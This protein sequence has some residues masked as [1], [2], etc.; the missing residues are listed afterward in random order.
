MKHLW[1]SNQRAAALALTLI[2]V[3]ILTA[4]TGSLIELGRADLGNAGHYISNIRAHSLAQS[5]LEHALQRLT[6][7][8][9]FHDSVH[10]DCS[11]GS[12]EFHFDPSL[13]NYSVNNLLGGAPSSQLN[14]QSNVVAP[15]RVDLVVLGRSGSVSTRLHAVCTS[16]LSLT[17]SAGSD[18]SI[19]IQNTSEVGGIRSLADPVPVGG[20]LFTHFVS[21]STAVPSISV[22]VS[23]FTISSSSTVAAP[24][25]NGGQDIAGNVPVAQKRSQCSDK[26]PDID[27]HDLVSLQSALSAPSGLTPLGPGYQVF[28]PS[29]SG[30]K[31]VDKDLVVRGDLQLNRGSLYIKGDLTV[32]GGVTGEGSIF[33][34]GNVKILGGTSSLRTNQ[35]TGAAVYAQ[36]NVTLEGINAVGYINSLATTHPAL[37]AELNNLLSLPSPIPGQV[38]QRLQEMKSINTNDDAW[39]G[40]TFI[41]GYAAG[42]DLATFD[43]NRCGVLGQAIQGPDGTRG[44]SGAKNALLR[45]A[46]EIKAALG[47]GYSSDD[48]AQQIVRGLE[49]LSYQCRGSLFTMTDNLQPDYTPISGIS[50][51]TNT[52]WDDNVYLPVGQRDAVPSVPALYTNS[53]WSST[54]M[55]WDTAKQQAYGTIFPSLSLDHQYRV[56]FLSLSPPAPQLVSKFRKQLNA[57]AQWNPADL[58]W[59]GTSNLQGIVYAHG[60]LTIKNDFNLYGTA[61]AH[62]EIDVSQNSKLIYVEEYGRTIG[63][64]GPVQLL[65]KNEI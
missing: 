65:W 16:G 8:A 59:L 25:P 34:D 17:K 48:R 13:P 57:I 11:T 55:T 40:A 6:F 33:S 5:G 24:K 27:V 45:T 39:A 21:T 22:P 18:K 38:P 60:K 50:T 63:T 42:E 41:G 14:S 31:Y 2:M 64:S 32:Y 62:E 10:V 35:S 26:V 51:Y 30:A 23:T 58:S 19:R 7:D 3:L 15:Y 47:A 29:M 28:S 20:G 44:Q 56:L 1:R 49:E 46:R 4:M 53:T 54:T 61:L 9:G 52:T 37:Q 43:I 12:Y 36:G